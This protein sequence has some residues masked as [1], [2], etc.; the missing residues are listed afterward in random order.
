MINQI[1]GELYWN[2]LEQIKKDFCKD[3]PSYRVGYDTSH[4]DFLKISARRIFRDYIH[5]INTGSFSCFA[6]KYP[7]ASVITQF[8]SSSLFSELKNDLEYVKLYLI[9]EAARDE[10]KYR[11][12]FLRL[13]FEAKG[14]PK[15]VLKYQ[16]ENNLQV[17][18]Q[19]FLDYKN[20]NY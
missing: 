13:G 10:L 17:I 7:D 1:L 4:E 5:A 20:K 14:L 3:H 8:N 6:D 12:E 11:M 19:A 15:S 16:Y 2:E 9:S 18:F